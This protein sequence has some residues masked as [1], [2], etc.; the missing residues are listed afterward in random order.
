MRLFHRS[1][2]LLQRPH[3]RVQ[4]QVDRNEVERTMRTYSSLSRPKTSLITW[5]HEDQLNLTLISSQEKPTEAKSSFTAVTGTSLFHTLTQWKTSSLPSD[6]ENH[7]FTTHGLQEASMDNMQV[8][9]NFT[10]D[11]CSWPWR[12]P[13]TKYH[14]Q[15]EK[16]LSR[17]SKTLWADTQSSN[18]C[19][20]TW[21]PNSI[22]IN[23]WSD[24]LMSM[25][26]IHSTFSYI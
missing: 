25:F 8:S 2:K 1:F 17:F 19:Q 14:N 7:T 16:Q 23:E 13:H 18:T 12:A 10:Q 24:N 26:I 21:K 20:K 5:T 3:F 11:F 15:R 6:W 22:K 4:S 9:P